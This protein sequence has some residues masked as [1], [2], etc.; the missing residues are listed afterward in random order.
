MVNRDRLDNIVLEKVAE[1]LLSDSNLQLLA[2]EVNKELYG[3]E[4]RISEQ[5]HLF[6]AQLHKKQKQLSRLVDAVETGQI[7]ASAL[8]PRINAR[9]V[10]VEKLLTKLRQL[11]QQDEITEA[12]AIDLER[13]RPYVES[14]KNT[15]STAPVTTQRSVLQSFIRDIEVGKDQLSIEFTIPRENTDREEDFTSVL[16][17]VKPG[18]PERTRTS[19]LRFRKPLLCP[20]ELRAHSEFF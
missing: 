11:D 9:Q 6:T 4:E 10:E 13:V 5:Q 12:S 18:T 15:L 8:Q 7:T 17:T 20:T 14:L 3:S 1:V 19:D 2:E 16:G